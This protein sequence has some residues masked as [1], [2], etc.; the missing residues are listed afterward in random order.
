[1]PA[2]RSAIVV[3]LVEVSP[4]LQHRQQMAFSGIDVPIVW[5][6]SLDEVPEG[7]AIVLANEFVDALPI[8]QAIKQLNGW[9]ER[10]V[11]IDS[12]DNL[13]FGIANEQIPLFEQLVPSDV[14]DAPL[15]A[16]YEWRNDNLALGLGQRVTRQ[17]G[18]ALLI[19]YGHA[20][21]A[22]GDTL[23]AIR[24]QTQAD[25]LTSPGEADL[26]AHVDFQAMT[27]AAESMGA[28][29]HG[30]IEQGVFLKTLGIEKRAAALKAYAPKDKA[31]AIDTAARRLIA[32]GRT[33][34]GRLFKVLAIADPQLVSLPGFRDAA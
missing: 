18:A 1:M 8:H 7:P 23:Q 5:H 3:H 16:I 22:V 25:P 27:T 34:M 15:G 14:R 33:D 12:E 6:Q 10:V 32:E 31:D 13:V 17:S 28:R 4:I 24:G 21:S 26:T 30:P 9:Y 29:V 2:F 19:D 11:E 20:K